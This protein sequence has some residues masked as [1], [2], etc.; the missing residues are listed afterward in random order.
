MADVR[1]RDVIAVFVVKRRRTVSATKQKTLKLQV[2]F[3][4]E[5]QKMF[6]HRVTDANVQI[7]TRARPIFIGR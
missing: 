4:F 3:L 7:E 5:Q 2:S 6:F 1:N